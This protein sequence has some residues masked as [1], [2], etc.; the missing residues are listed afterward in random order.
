M[1]HLRGVPNPDA[2]VPPN[3]GRPV[4]RSCCTV[5]LLSIVT[6]ALS[7][8]AARTRKR[9]SYRANIS[10]SSAK[11]SAG[12]VHGHTR[13][14]RTNSWPSVRGQAKAGF[15]ARTR[16][17]S[18]HR[19]AH[20]AQG[21]RSGRNKRSTAAKD[22]FKRQQPCPSTGR[23]SGPCPGYVID[24]VSP[25][26]CNGADSPSNMQWQT[27]ADGKAKDKTERYCR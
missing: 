19:P 16:S 9:Y 23:S 24:H 4:S 7:T 22:E 3:R 27:V 25:L 8:F 11:P 18:I 5:L 2:N 13:R 15:H 1:Y 20:F 10:R 14:H 26:E 12:Y 6:V 17:R 21:T